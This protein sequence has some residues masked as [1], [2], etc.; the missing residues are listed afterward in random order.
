ML[1][2]A[3]RRMGHNPAHLSGQLLCSSQIL[4]QL[5]N[6]CGAGLVSRRRRSCGL[7]Q[8]CN[9]CL[10]RSQL[11]LNCLVIRLQSCLGSSA[12]RKLCERGILPMR[13][14]PSD[15]RNALHEARLTPGVAFSNSSD[16]NKIFSLG[17]QVL[18]G[19]ST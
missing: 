8:G 19:G 11:P 12:R 15:Q 7:P 4:P 9:V 13:V 14:K 17:Q 1:Q 5:L 6:T 18:S 3:V 10:S 16:Y 2:D